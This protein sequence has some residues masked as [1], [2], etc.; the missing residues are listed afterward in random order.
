MVCNTDTVEK[1]NCK[2]NANDAMCTE[3]DCLCR[4]RVSIDLC[5]GRVSID[6]CRGPMSF[7]LCRGLVCPLTGSQRGD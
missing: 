4:G 6:L 3:L 2:D 1:S 7:D 5:R